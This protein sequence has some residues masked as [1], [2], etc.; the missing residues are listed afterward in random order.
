MKQTWYV[1]LFAKY[2]AYV[3]QINEYVNQLLED[4]HHSSESVQPTSLKYCV[5][6]EQ[7]EFFI[8]CEFIDNVLSYD[9]L[10]DTVIR[11]YLDS[12]IDTDKFNTLK[13]DVNA[14]MA[15]ELSINMNVPSC[16]AHFELLFA[17]YNAIIRRQSLKWIIEKNPKGAL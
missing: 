4:K 15:K 8:D 9:A 13:T 1:L 10:T 17:S 3:L 6:R 14:I 11:M 2:D 7:L 5:D 12:R 16:H